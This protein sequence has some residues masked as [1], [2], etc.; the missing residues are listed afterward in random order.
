MRR[1]DFRFNNVSCWDMGAAVATRPSIPAPERRGEFVEI[2]GRDGALLVSDGT[3]ENIEIEVALNIVRRQDK[4]MQSYR[5][6][7]NWLNG[8]GELTFSDDADIF[9]RVKAVGITD[10]ERRARIGADIEATFICDPFAYYY[11]GKQQYP[12][13]EAQLNPYYTANPLYH[14]AG[15][16]VCYLTVNGNVMGA[17]IGGNLT[18]DTDRRLAYRDDGML[19]NA[20][21]SGASYEDMVLNN[22]QNVITITDGFTLTVTPNWRSI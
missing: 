19:R 17:N 18:I 2:A 9:Y 11:S 3:Y 22:G 13:N 7:K 8:S 4:V 21:I 14:I 16:G 5:V 10:F 12:Y 1:Y 15:E 6:I 20:S